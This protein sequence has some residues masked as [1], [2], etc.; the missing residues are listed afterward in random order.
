MHKHPPCSDW[1]QKVLSN[2][3][4]EP[5]QLRELKKKLAKIKCSCS[6]CKISSRLQQHPV[7]D[8]KK[9]LEVTDN[10][11]IGYPKK[12]VDVTEKHP[13]L[14]E[15]P[16]NYRS[17]EQ[18]YWANLNAD[19]TRKRHPVGDPKK[20]VEVTDREQKIDRVQWIYIPNKSVE[21]QSLESYRSNQNEEVLKL[22]DISK[23]KLQPN[24][25]DKLKDREKPAVVLVSNET[26]TDDLRFPK[27][28]PFLHRD[29]ND[30][31]P[32]CYFT[33]DLL[34]S[35]KSTVL[36]DE[37][38]ETKSEIHACNKSTSN[39]I[40]SMTRSTSYNKPLLKYPLTSESYDSLNAENPIRREV[41][42]A[43]N[44]NQYYDHHARSYTHIPI[45]VDTSSP[46]VVENYHI[47]EEEETSTTMFDAIPEIG[48]AS[49]P[50]CE[51]CEH[52]HDMD[53]Q[54][55]VNSISP[56]HNRYYFTS[57]YNNNC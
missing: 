7:G 4:W 35:N 40:I 22:L 14:L 30:L 12:D 28:F 54:N 44:N 39:N 3:L 57:R 48:D 1:T 17:I 26:I 42:F 37:E 45:G 29:Q 15:D 52:W 2:G 33:L 43:F 53:I 9:D 49:S 38:I 47:D 41:T 50:E 6:L 5:V 46:E 18:L 10:Q 8:P 23:S 25:T 56:P 36:K 55:L 11:P 32:S 13:V 24:N 27:K 51:Y 31:C 16:K 20:G 34:R 19:V 21:T